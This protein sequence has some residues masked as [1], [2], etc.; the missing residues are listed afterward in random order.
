MCGKTFLTRK[1]KMVN[2]QY[3]IAHIYPNSPNI[4]QIKELCGLERVGKTCEDADQYQSL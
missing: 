2:K 1:G 3:R 4:H